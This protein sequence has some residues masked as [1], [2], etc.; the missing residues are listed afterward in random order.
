MSYTRYHTSPRQSKTLSK[1]RIAHVT[2][3]L[4]RFA[5]GVGAV[6]ASLSAEQFALGHD[7]RVLGLDSAE[8]S[9]A[10]HALWTGAPAEAFTIA[11]GPAAFGFAPKLARR[12]SDFAPDIVHLHGLWQYPT[13]AVLNWH[14]R[15]G[16]PY[17]YSPHGMLSPVALGYSPLKK[18]IV[19]TLFQ[20]RALNSATILHATAD[21]ETDEFRCFGLSNSVS[22]VPLG[23]DTAVVPVQSDRQEK[24]VL[25]LGRIHRKKNL[26]V[27]IEAWSRLEPHFPAWR[28]ELI[29]PDEGGHLAELQ[30]LAA[31]LQVLRVGF[32]PAVP[33]TERNAVMAAADIFV[34]PTRSENFALTVAESLMMETPVIATRGAPWPGLVQEGCGW[35]IDQGLN[36][37]VTALEEA[38]CLTDEQRKS[39]GRRGREWM[40]RDFSW[41]T[42]AERMI[43]VYQNAIGT[44]PEWAGALQEARFP[45]QKE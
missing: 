28:L 21:A 41:R 11:A 22:V 45:D 26:A 42:V 32:H 33:P 20:D 24:R 14:L 40:L 43:A 35:W 12:L 39:M 6:V 19:R 27:L 5:A 23:I 7:V 16:K 18:R 34:L 3:G 17:V 15:T 9:R 36:P 30:A 44:S 25:S 10:D 1:M 13:L 8:W 29:G 4:D 31:R 37:L 2:S 38:M